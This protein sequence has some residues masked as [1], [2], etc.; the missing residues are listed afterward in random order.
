MA[1][2]LGFHCLNMSHK[3]DAMLVWGKLFIHLAIEITSI[4]VF[5]YSS[6]KQMLKSG[7]LHYIPFQCYQ[8]N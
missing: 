6:V 2:D 1:S 7:P 4:D 3:T 8:V 5:I